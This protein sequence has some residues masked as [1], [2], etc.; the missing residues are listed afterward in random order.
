MTA[1]GQAAIALGLA[2]PPDPLAPGPFRLADA[3]ALQRLLERAG[4]TIEAVEDVAVTWRSASL[5]DWWEAITD[6]S[7]NL[8]ALLGQLA[9]A[10]AAA[11][12]AAAVELL[13]DFVTPDG[14]VAAP[15]VAR[16]VLARR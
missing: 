10:D 13:S 2:E 5:D 16:A 12:R 7:P 9:P 6:L 4:L 8:A 15:G 14:S 11:L 1:G 3:T